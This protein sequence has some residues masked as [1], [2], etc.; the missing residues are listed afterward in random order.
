VKVNHEGTYNFFAFFHTSLDS[1]DVALSLIVQNARLKLVLSN[2]GQI[3]LGGELAL[4]E[5]L[6]GLPCRH[7]EI[8]IA[9]N[10]ISADEIKCAVFVVEVLFGRLGA[11]CWLLRQKPGGSLCAEGAQSLSRP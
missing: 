5:A 10:S 3:L 7:F 4:P 11:G 8:F 9:M 6:V 2:Y 1:G